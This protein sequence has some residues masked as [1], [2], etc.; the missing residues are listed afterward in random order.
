M[1]KKILLTI[2]ALFGVLL[3]GAL[4]LAYANWD[5]AYITTIGTWSVV[6]RFSYM[7]LLMLLFSG[8]TMLIWDD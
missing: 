7:L 4:L 8:L 1:T 6:D 2:L 5:I 3:F